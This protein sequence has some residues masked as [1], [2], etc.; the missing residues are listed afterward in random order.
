MSTSQAEITGAITSEFNK[1]RNAAAI[2]QA[3]DFVEQSQRTRRLPQLAEPRA[4][5]GA[6]TCSNVGQRRDSRQQCPN[7]FVHAVRWNLNKYSFIIG[8]LHV[9]HVESIDVVTDQ[10]NTDDGFSFQDVSCRSKKI[11]FTFEPPPWLSSLIVKID[12]AMQVSQPDFTPQIHWRC[13]PQ[14]PHLVPLVDEL[15]QVSSLSSDRKL[16]AIAM[17]SEL[18]AAFEV[19]HRAEIS[20]GDMTHLIRRSWLIAWK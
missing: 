9:E 11:R 3:F 14:G 1:F 8:T 5:R 13:V 4:P 18:D 17:I 12:I 16:M 6:L 19:R 2:G 15:H 7:G 10:V 20:L